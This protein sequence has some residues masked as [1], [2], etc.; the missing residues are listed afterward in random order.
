MA[1]QGDNAL[2]GNG[3]CH[4]EVTGLSGVHGPSPTT[5]GR[6]GLQAVPAGDMIKHRLN[7]LYQ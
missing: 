5:R 2:Y 6:V 1:T 4:D 7:L 3:E